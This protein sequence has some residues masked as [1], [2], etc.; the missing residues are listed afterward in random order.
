M[1]MCT[2]ACT[3]YQSLGLA[4]QYQEDFED[5]IYE[6]MVAEPAK[7]AAVPVK[8]KR[9]RGRKNAQIIWPISEDV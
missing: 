1:I 3:D 2:S 5:D 6:P 9:G 8:R 7:Y 4:L